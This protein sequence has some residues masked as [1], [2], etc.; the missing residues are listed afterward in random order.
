LDI[1]GDKW[2][3]LLIRDLACGKS[4]FKEFA[5]SPEKIATNILSERL[6]RLLE[7][8]LVETVSSEN[9]ARVGYQLTAKGKTLLPVLQSIADWGLAHIEGT[10][11]HMKPRIE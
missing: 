8:E 1:F 3:L 5:L 11:A 4:L 10:E 9:S 7:Y 6:R 2:T